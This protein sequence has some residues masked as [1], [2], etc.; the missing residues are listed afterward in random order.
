MEILFFAM[1]GQESRATQ[2]NIRKRLYTDCAVNEARRS[3]L[4]K[5]VTGSI[6]TI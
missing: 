1:F 2:S 6:L 5:F 3:T 4:T